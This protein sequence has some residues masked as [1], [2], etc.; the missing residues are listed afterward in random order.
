MKRFIKIIALILSL[1]CIFSLVACSSEDSDDKD[2][3]KNNEKNNVS[4]DD[5]KNA[6]ECSH[7]F[8][9]WK[10]EKEPDCENKGSKSR[11]CSKCDLKQHE[12]IPVGDHKFG[13]F[14]ITKAAT[15]KAT[16]TQTRTCSV[17][18]KTETETI[19]KSEHK[20]GADG[21]ALKCTLCSEA[22]YSVGTQGLL[23]KLQGANDPYP[24]TYMVSVG[25]AITATDIVIPATYKG[26]AVTC[27]AEEG[28]TAA[29]KLVNISIPASVKKIGDNAFVDCTKLESVG[30]QSGSQLE[31]LTGFYRCTSLASIRVPASVTRIEASAFRGCTALNGIYFDDTNNWYIGNMGSSRSE[32]V[33]GNDSHAAANTFKYEANNYYYFKLTT[34]AE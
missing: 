19:A 6:G 9:E 8:G 16:G 18:N 22:N 28:F 3:G 7:D 31:V 11:Q 32:K 4:K 10:I 30:F 25:T 21:K 34:P 15:C 20:F 5:D 2:K 14:S 24:D 12:A 1:L 26:K 27:I 17:C 23:F 13:A 29:E 33:D